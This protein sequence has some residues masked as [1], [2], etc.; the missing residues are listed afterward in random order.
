LLQKYLQEESERERER[1]TEKG[2]REQVRSREYRQHLNSA[3]FANKITA[4]GYRF[5]HYYYINLAELTYS[6]R[7]CAILILKIHK[8]MSLLKSLNIQ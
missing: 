6:L 3:S 5:N 8:I 4:F 1:A 7:N 2:E